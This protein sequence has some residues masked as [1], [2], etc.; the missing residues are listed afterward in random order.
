MSP[1]ERQNL[2]ALYHKTG[3][4]HITLSDADLTAYAALRKKEYQER[5][6]EL[7]TQGKTNIKPVKDEAGDIIGWTWQDPAP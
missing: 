5:R 2:L 1:V 4:G 3:G 7:K 6:N